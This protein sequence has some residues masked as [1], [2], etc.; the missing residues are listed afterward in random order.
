MKTVKMY[1]TVKYIITLKW[2]KVTDVYINTLYIYIY[3]YR[4][5]NYDGSCRK[6]GK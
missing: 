4:N 1:T 2:L 3:V 6:P 5:K